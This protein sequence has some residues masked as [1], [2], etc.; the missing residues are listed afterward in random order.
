MRLKSW[1]GDLR[2]HLTCKERAHSTCCVLYSF[3]FLFFGRRTFFF[4]FC[5]FSGHLVLLQPARLTDS[6]HMNDFRVYWLCSTTSLLCSSYYPRERKRYN[7][8][9]SLYCLMAS[10]H[11]ISCFPSTNEPKNKKNLCFVI[12]KSER[13]SL[14]VQ[15]VDPTGWHGL[16]RE[17]KKTKSLTGL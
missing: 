6:F 10:M 15:R 3:F 14:P 2:C 9:F 4:L 5:S 1:R 11:Y 17:D 12:P 7:F 16:A 13:K 8:F